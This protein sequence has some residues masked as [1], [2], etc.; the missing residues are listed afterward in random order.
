MRY[1]V[2]EKFMDTV[3]RE[4]GRI[5]GRF[6]SEDYAQI[7]RDAVKYINDDCEVFVVSEY[8]LDRV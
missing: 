2:I 6:E 1:V 5:I 8:D 3:K 7:F 4:R